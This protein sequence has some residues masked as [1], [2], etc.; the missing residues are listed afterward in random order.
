[1]PNLI[2]A[3][4]ARLPFVALFIL[5]LVCAP[6]AVRGQGTS[7]T[8]S[9]FITDS[10]GAKIPGA[11]VTFTDVA[12]G[13]V[14]KTV[15]NGEGLYRLGALPPGIYNATVSMQGFKT[16]VQQGLDLHLEDQ[17]SLDYTLA[18][19]A[20][21]EEVTISANANILESQSPTV[22]QV[23]EG[24]QVEDTPLNG[25][26]TMNLVA[27][28]PGVVS[29]GGT[30]GAASNNTNG[31]A[32]TNANSFGNYSIAGGLA[33]QEAIFVDGA[34]VQANFGNATAYVITQDAVQEF[35]VE[36]S[37]VNPQYGRFG[38]GVISFGTKSG[39]NRIHGSVYEYF[40]NTI[41]NANNFFNNGAAIARPKFNQNQFG[42]TIGG[43]VIKDKA[44]YFGSYEGYRLAQGV[45]N[46]GL[47]PTPAELSGDFTQNGDLAT[48]VFNPV[49][50]SNA[51]GTPYTPFVPG[52][53]AYYRQATCGG[54]VNKF[55]IGA[56][57]NPGDAV[58][59]PTAQYLANTLHYFPTPN[60]AGNAA[61]NY[62]ANGKANSFTNQETFRLDYALGIRSKLFARYTRF[63]RTQNPTVFFTN[64]GGP[65]SYTG[66]GATASQYVLGDTVTLTPTSILDVR[67][68][69][70]R[71]FSYLQPA[72]T[73]V[74]L[75]P[76]DNGD[77][78]SFWSAASHELPTYLPG[79]IITNNT[80][81]PYSGLD[82]GAQQPFNVYTF[83]GSYSK[84]LGK[85]SLT[86]GGELRQEEEYLYNQ[87]FLAGA[88]IFAG[89]NTSCI[90]S[91][92]TT[93]T[94]NDVTRPAASKS[95][96]GPPTIPGSGPTPTSD[97]VSGQFTTTPTGFTTTIPRSG[98]SHYAGIF[99]N[100]TFAISPKLTI[101]AGVRYEHP[102][103]NFEKNDQNAVILPQFANPLV[104]V[105][106]AAYSYRGDL[107]PHNTL[108]SPRVGFSYAPRVGTTFRAGYGL[109]FIPQD[110]DFYNTP[111]YSTIN[112]PQTFVPASQ[113]LC[114]PLGFAAGGAGG[115]NTPGTIAKTAILQPTGGRAGYLANPN[116]FVGQALQGRNPYGGYAYL[117]Q[118]NANVQQALDGSTVLQLAY[119]GAR[120]EH[121]PISNVFNINQLPDTAPVGGASQS[122]RPYPLY[123]N[124]NET[125]PFIG[126]T[127]YNSAQVTVTK[128]FKSGGT[129]LGNY[130]W[131]KFLGTA[132]S[133]T[134]QVESH[135]EGL[136]Q[137]YTNIRAERSYL[138]FDI[139]QRLV[140][141][142]ILDLPVGRGKHFLKNAGP[143]LN[144]FVSG[145]NA[146]GIN[147][148]Q[149]G[150]PLAIIGAPN[151][152]SAAFGGGTPRPNI[153]SGCALHSG[154]GLVT[155]AQTGTSTFNKAC[156]SSPVY[157]GISA[158]SLLGNAPR[159]IG[160]LRTQGVDNWDFSLGK[161]T[162]IH[163]DVN[164]VFRA[165]AFNV[166]NRVQFGDPGVTVGS[167]T[168]GVPVSQANS[169]RSFQFSLRLN[170]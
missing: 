149:S 87:P 161:T 157:N 42:A 99:A 18:I 6:I 138:S 109:S 58:A 158:A 102:G 15:T 104:L 127:Y 105:N 63:D 62:Q 17:V 129:I 107:V 30:N 25:R 79:I 90:P 141:S 26:N 20:S 133:T 124:V 38:G 10:T 47:V 91:A 21:S 77:Q 41:F 73:N 19:G 39:G 76:L 167:A 122:L 37:V 36:S 16:A 40:R 50:G 93:V 85:H 151:A 103:N 126:D 67:L 78:A 125:G 33:T 148:L 83:F 144:S 66:V 166:F 57:V 112:S 111:N 143:A 168:F 64:P 86:L 92:A 150:F 134:S 84:V 88:F 69:Y 156:F 12:T 119:L 145:W 45:I 72:N 5:M 49:P 89:T 24:R 120:G 1:M 71:Y 9:G 164:L 14:A 11:T 8:V 22:S 81:F 115:C 116:E 140:V 153:V 130:S 55:C 3:S 101:T 31:G 121:L 147:S 170:Y 70:L 152:L 131:S 155:A 169:P 13:S 51:P 61:R 137:D 100:D 113:L 35:R 2:S 53:P 28:T 162:P 136:I 117:E 23:I 96:G 43:A 54:V 98:L 75:A 118:W 34:P 165:E 132:E 52:G 80:T 95:C 82:Q 4:K 68:S 44:F 32:F 139:P 29:Q 74:N 60:L 142:Y 146:S 108:F 94:Y 46:T 154:V 123:Q 128:R 106:T 7:A 160:L 27:L 135:A 97:F 48:K 56:P 59:D 159:T 163:E 65:T 114:A 110:S